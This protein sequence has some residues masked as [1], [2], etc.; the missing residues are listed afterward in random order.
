MRTNATLKGV[1]SVSVPAKMRTCPRSSAG[2]GV[3]FIIPSPSSTSAVVPSMVS[4]TNTSP[5]GKPQ[6]EVDR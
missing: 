3:N 4:A 2:F 6:L 1:S 5:V